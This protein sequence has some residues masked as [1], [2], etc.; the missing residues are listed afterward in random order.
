MKA[1]NHRK[2]KTSCAVALALLT[3][4]FSAITYA[5]DAQENKKKEAEDDV[6]V[7]AV[8]GAIRKSFEGSIGIKRTADTVVDAITAEDLG[9]FSDASIA[10]AIQRIPGVQVETDDSGT[11]GDRVSIRGLGP[12]F[13]NSTINGR[14]LL[15]SG[16]EA[17][18]LRQMNF[19]VFPSSVLGGVQVAKGQTAARPESGLAGQVDLQT[20][21]PLDIGKLKD[22]S[23]FATVSVEGRYQDVSDEGGFRVNTI[24]GVRNEE[25]TLGGYVAFAYADEKNARDQIRVNSA[26]RNIQL[27]NNGDGVADETVSGVRVPTA[28][29]LN[30]IRES[31]ERVSIAA[32]VQYEPTDDLNINWDL[33]YSEYA[34]D[35]RRQTP[36]IQMGASY[37]SIFD[38]SDA[39]NPGIVIDENNVAQQIN[40]AQSTGGGVI[41]PILRPMV[42]DNT[43][44]NLITGINFDYYISDNLSSNFDVYYSS[45]DYSQDLR[46]SQIRKNTDKSQFS[47]DATGTVPVFNSDINDTDGYVYFQSIVREIELEAD[48]VGATVKF[49]Y[50]LQD[51]PIVSID[52]GAH[53]DVTNI[54]K[55]FGGLTQLRNPE[56]AG[57]LLAAGLPGTMTDQN[58]MPD[59]NFTPSRWLY[60]DYDAI[61]AIETDLTTVQLTEDSIDPT[62]SYEMTESILA[63]FA[64]A[65]LDTI[66]FDKKLTGNL[67][68]RAVHTDQDASAAEFVND[69][70]QP[71]TTQGDYWEYLPSLNLSLSMQEDLILRFG[72]SKT[73]TRP[74]YEVMAPLNTVRTP[75]EVEGDED[76]VGNAK[77]GNP[78]LDPMTSLNTDLTLEWYTENDGAF[79]ASVFHKDVKDFVFSQTDQEVPLNN[80]EGLY[81]VTTYINYSDGEAKGLELGMYQPFDK[82]FPSLTG[83]GISANYTYVDSS[84]DLDTGDSGFGFPGSSEDNFNFIA[85]YDQDA[86]SVRLA[87]VYRSD[88]FR[89]LAGT[90]AQVDSAIFTEAQSKLDLSVVLRPTEDLSFRVN[91]GNLTDE[92]RRDFIGQK[93]TFLDYYDRGRTYSIT[94]SYDF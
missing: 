69:V 13:V 22:E 25:H 27:D 49:N 43:T 14:R 81:N 64:Q 75:E 29:T 66:V 19:N 63:F 1:M 62:A 16:T 74:D 18:S 90:G 28:I 83:F 21:R 80:Y 78:K 67:G 31:T 87:Y 26:L 54:D 2:N 56:M 73:L 32:G 40:Y 82:I 42:F 45:V 20:L 44:E 93:T 7:I 58:F 3:T 50:L 65:N 53:Y 91:V 57:E 60:T 79:I 68:L 59:E 17:R 47:Y 23:T 46:F 15:S 92:N 77:I 10:G 61:A 51:G 35:S 6:E 33:M 94:A 4:S 48:N 9:Q 37:T 39:N 41:R 38:M 89:Q 71:V 85:F 11:Q 76:A 86:Y 36:Q 8:Y 52:F 24:A 72:I 12:Q 34:N 84:F 55:D 88:F 5:Q 30:P 70:A